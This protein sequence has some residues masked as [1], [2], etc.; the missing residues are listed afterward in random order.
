M[1]QPGQ[2]PSQQPISFK[3]VPGRNRTQKWTQ[4][5][6][7][8]YD[9]DDWG[10]YDD[11]DDYG[12][13]QDQQSEPQLQRQPS[14]DRGVDTEK[15]QFSSGT[16]IH[17]Q[18][19]YTSPSGSGGQIIQD[20]SSPDS[21][22]RRMREFSNPGQVP[23][24]LNTPRSPPTPAS[25]ERPPRKS[26]LVSGSPAPDARAA[27]ATTSPV[28]DK[29][30]PFIRPS[31]IYKR[32]AE[33]HHKES[34]SMESGRPSMD[35]VQ[36][37]V[38]SPSSAHHAGSLP[39]NSDRRPSLDPANET[40][41][42]KPLSPEPSLPAVSETF[43]PSMTIAQPT[44]QSEDAQPSLR[45]ED[46]SP[47]LPPVSRVSGF[48]SFMPRD[49]EEERISATGLAAST[50]AANAAASALSSGSRD[51]TRT[52]PSHQFQH[53]Y[54]HSGQSS[55]PAADIAAERS[56]EAPVE[57]LGR[58]ADEDPSGLSHRPSSG[59]RSVVH[60][61]FDRQGDGSVPASPISRDNT[62]S[63]VSRSDTNSTRS[64]S[65]IMS[66][67][68]SAA[69][70][71]QKQQERDAVVPP[72]AEETPLEVA[73]SRPTQDSAAP[74][75]SSRPSILRKPTP[76]HS[77]NVSSEIAGFTPGYRRSMDTPSPNNS[78]ARTPGLGDTDRRRL[79]GPMAAVTVTDPEAPD[80]DPSAPEMPSAVLAPAITP[81]E[82]PG[83]TD[84]PA[85]GTD[86]VKPLPTTGRGRSGTDYSVRESDLAREANNS[87]EDVAQAATIQQNLFLDT[88]PSNPGTPTTMSP[89]TGLPRPFPLPAGAGSGR[90]SPA[91]ASHSRVRNIVDQ[92]HQIDNDS[93]RNSAA[94][95]MSSKSS[96]SNF[97]GEEDVTPGINRRATGGP[98]NSQQTTGTPAEEDMFPSYE[99]AD[100]ESAAAPG[101]TSP[102]R[103]A[104]E[105]LESFKP[106]LPGEWISAAPTP[107][108]EVPAQISPDARG[109]DHTSREI[110]T[111]SPPTPRGQQFA[112]PDEEVDLTPTT[113]K[114][115]LPGG[116]HS[117]DVDESQSA[118]A[119]VKNAGDALG[120]A[121]MSSVGY[122]HQAQ[123][124]ATKDQ[125]APV[126]IPEMRPHRQTGAIDSLSVPA[127]RR[128]DSDA[129]S[130]AT[131]S[132]AN[133]VPPTPPAKD[134]PQPPGLGANIG[135][136]GDRPVSN[137]FAGYIPD[138]PAPLSF[139]K[140]SPS[141]SQ[142]FAASRPSMLPALSTDTR[143]TDFESDR[144]RKDIVRS[145]GPEKMAE[146]KRESILE[147][148][149]HTQDALD[150]PSN[151]HRV[152]SGHSALPAAEIQNAEG[153]SGLP[154]QAKPGLLNQ[155]FSW[156]N[157]STDDSDDLS[158]H[159]AVVGETK[160]D[161]N[162]ES[163]GRPHSDQGLHVV[164]TEVTADSEPTT[165]E[166][167]KQAEPRFM[168]NEPAEAE[169]RLSAALPIGTAA[170]ALG[171]HGDAPHDDGVSLVSENPERERGGLDMMAPTP[172]VEEVDEAGRAAEPQS[173]SVPVK[174]ASPNLSSA[175][176]AAPQPAAA[177]Q[178]KIPAFRD[179]A[180]IKSADDRIAAY[181]STRHRF[182]DMNTGLSGWLSDMLVA[183]PEYANAG[184][185]KYEGPA[186][187]QTTNLSNTISGL[188]GTIRG[189]SHKHSP[190][191]LKIGGE[192]K[193]STTS[194]S[195]T[196]P[197]T[198]STGGSG[199]ADVEKMQ[200]KG[201]DFMKSAGA[202][203][204]GLF[205]KGKSRFGRGGE[206]VE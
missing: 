1:S 93:R 81:L 164:N 114:M 87:P 50:A 139:G 145:L 155:R 94:S 23:Q 159:M 171:S 190:S 58:S 138:A 162:R 121:L 201:K 175:S 157:R 191:I 18:D 176:T 170:L 86:F 136:T 11:Y 119:A 40:K 28:N 132:V 110:A 12:G 95:G 105:R 109:R 78:P 44:A 199:H 70:A 24:P 120:T 116:Y 174:D 96:W 104:T 181:D 61:A 34:Q 31:D 124:F 165:A 135:P 38:G 141:G 72:I 62:Q 167:D 152:A 41:E 29:P 182:A 101:L 30:L 14:F 9:G 97:G 179:L 128:E 47:R 7:N 188:G 142:D 203:A 195:A 200:A 185:Q 71:Q 123:D 153:R 117:P 161:E 183:H 25:V 84:V 22:R 168:L 192:R 160:G 147:D 83:S 53:S 198:G 144:L 43:A 98:A 111:A 99:Q 184:N 76:S 2:N 169:K 140:P 151:E 17:D 196:T 27:P 186:V 108:N 205:A 37:E 127:L 202:G 8:N 91:G 197:T 166:E 74:A 13:Y 45:P 187:I 163:Y 16:A 148:G 150:A 129:P 36:R 54:D 77:R 177:P 156:E 65:P 26:S 115:K 107:A 118:L 149:D 173:P 60:K 206:K 102:S 112:N 51:V 88:H 90:D 6:T 146:L 75:M 204:K 33:E 66:R 15:R 73:R 80:V 10:G 56:T 158:S 180:A 20:G 131:N 4:A 21:T 103:P 143:P 68:P 130:E 82:T 106:H 85:N 42:S 32:M 172:M 59:F 19:R 48:G 92:Y 46:S 193:A 67:V 125:A 69:T 3:T 39:S 64:I 122:G 79:S 133:S 52:M 126:D 57:L 63:E 178:S 89:S 194:N 189:A 113:K 49:D 100:Q 5:K 35:S 55:D 134:T 137:Y 154:S